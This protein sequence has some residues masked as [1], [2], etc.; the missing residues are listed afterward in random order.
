M[1]KFYFAVFKIMPC[2]HLKKAFGFETKSIV[3]PLQKAAFV[4]GEP[5]LSCAQKAVNVVDKLVA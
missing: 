1:V 5:A 3:A 4:I 2:K